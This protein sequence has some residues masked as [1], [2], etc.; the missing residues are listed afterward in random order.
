MTFQTIEWIFTDRF[1]ILMTSTPWNILATR[2]HFRK[3]HIQQKRNT[4]IMTLRKML[5]EPSAMNHCNTYLTKKSS[6]FKNG[7]NRNHQWHHLHLSQNYRG[8]NLHLKPNLILKSNLHLT[9]WPNPWFH[10][11]CHPRS[12]NSCSQRSPTYTS[13]FQES[14]TQ[15]AQDLKFNILL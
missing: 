11:S 13:S 5:N 14:K 15:C 12:W 8:H 1:S 7:K 3:T 2:S 10:L 9:H 6:T 4:S